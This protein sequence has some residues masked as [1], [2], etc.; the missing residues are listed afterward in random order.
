MSELVE[1]KVRPVG[2]AL[3]FILPSR[4]VKS[5]KLR[6]G[7]TV[8]ISIVKQKAGVASLFGLTRGA[9]LFEREH[10]ERRH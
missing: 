7:E 2:N 8:K 9:S 4:L 6:S 1:V 5:E 10:D 3:G